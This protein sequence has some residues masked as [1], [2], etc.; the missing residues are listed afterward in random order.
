MVEYNIILGKSRKRETGMGE[1]GEA[2]GENLIFRNRV[3]CHANV[4]NP[5]HFLG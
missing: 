5:D 2:V 3:T 4:G 1:E